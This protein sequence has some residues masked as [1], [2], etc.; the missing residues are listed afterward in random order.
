MNRM[1]HVA[2]TLQDIWL[3]A[4]AGS[5]RCVCHRLTLNVVLSLTEQKKREK[6]KVEI[7]YVQDFIVL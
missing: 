4:I 5:L 1:L 6:N 3:V 7:F 2:V